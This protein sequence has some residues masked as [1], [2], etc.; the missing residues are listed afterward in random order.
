MAEIIE[1]PFWLVH[2]GSALTL[3]VRSFDP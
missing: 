3:L 2:S 1:M